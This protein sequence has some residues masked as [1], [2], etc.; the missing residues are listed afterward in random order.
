MSTDYFTGF[1]PA[2]CAG[3]GLLLAGGVNLALLNK[4]LKLRIPA[5]L[6]ALS[7][8]LAAAASVDEMT[9]S[10]A[11][12]STA[13]LL[14]YGLVP[15]LLLCSR[16][17]VAGIAATVTATHR[18]AVRFGLLTVGGLVMVLAA[19]HSFERADEI[20]TENTIAALDIS[21]DRVPSAPAT[22]VKATTDLG[23][24]ILLEEPMGQNPANLLA[25]EAKTLHDASL[26]EY[27]IRRGVANNHCN[28][29][30]WVFTGGKFLLS[31]DEIEVIL[32]ENGYHEVREV[33]I[34]D[35]VLY[36]QNGGVSH[37]GLVRYVAEGQPVLV[38]SKW[39]N[40]GVFLH[41]VDKSVYGTEFTFHRSGRAGHALT[42]L[43]SPVRPTDPAHTGVTE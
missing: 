41:P 33:H 5:T 24:A 20:N 21:L 38:E 27:V 40:L 17:L 14:A 7:L 37:T 26:N 18:P 6:L 43:G 22:W 1:F 32:K 11:L 28:C 4:S 36:R 42:G 35:V 2:V 25:T 10:D 3:F 16:R 15:C 34:G 23:T 39:G 13:K 19:F 29:H 8:A 9:G 30:G 12:A 31:G